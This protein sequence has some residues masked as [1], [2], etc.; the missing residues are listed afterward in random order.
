MAQAQ[1]WERHIVEVLRGMPPDAPP[2]TVPKPGV[3]PAA[4]VADPQGAG[5]GSRADRCG[6]AGDRQRGQAAPPPL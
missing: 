5:Q 2:G 1:W 6:K 3:R 4:G